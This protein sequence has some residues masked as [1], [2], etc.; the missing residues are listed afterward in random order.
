MLKVPHGLKM[1]IKNL[2][3]CMNYFAFFFFVCL[4]LRSPH[5]GFTHSLSLTRT[6][7][8]NFERFVFHYSIFFVFLESTSPFSL[9]LQ[10]G[11]KTQSA[12]I[13]VSATVLKRPRSRCLETARGSRVCGILRWMADRDWEMKL[14]RLRE[15]PSEC[16]RGAWTIQVRAWN[17]VSGEVNGKIYSN[18]FH[19]LVLVLQIWFKHC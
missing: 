15:I 17:W 1:H 9:Q 12:I 11:G 13:C 16:W 7:I 4:F 5:N 19:S 3:Y 18:W 6:Q 10:M 2:Y 8:P 14:T